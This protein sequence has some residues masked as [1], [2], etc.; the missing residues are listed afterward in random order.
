MHLSDRIAVVRDGRIAAIGEPRRIYDNPVSRWIAAFLGDVNARDVEGWRDG[1][2]GYVVATL[3]GGGEA[4]ARGTDAAR[5]SER[6]T[7]VVRPER[8]RIS[9]VSTQPHNSFRGVVAGTSFLG[10][11]QRIRLVTDGG[12]EVLATVAGHSP[13]ALPGAVAFCE[14]DPDAALIVPDL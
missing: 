1:G 8:C 5:H 7:L 9:P 13:S 12:W 4:V 2:N 14:F 3:E 11:V 6:A 10:P